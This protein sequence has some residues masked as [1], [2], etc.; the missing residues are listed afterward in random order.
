MTR[1]QR[2]PFGYRLGRIWAGSQMLEHTLEKQRSLRTATLN[3][4]SVATLQQPSAKGTKGDYGAWPRIK[5]ALRVRG[6]RADRRACARSVS[7]GSIT[8]RLASGT[9]GS[10]EMKPLSSGS[11]SEDALPSVAALVA[12]KPVTVEEMLDLEALVEDTELIFKLLQLACE[13]FFFEFKDYVREQPD[14]L[15]PVNMVRGRRPHG[16]WPPPAGCIPHIAAGIATSR[17]RARDRS[18]GSHRGPQVQ[19]ALKYLHAIYTSIDRATIDLTER[20]LDLLVEMAD[21]SYT[22]QMVI[23]ENKGMCAPRVSSC[24]CCCCCSSNCLGPAPQR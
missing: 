7:S 23:F 12:P 16:C 24:C 20:N 9:S 6:W 1:P 14:S 17:P 18:G 11:Q 21:G 19:E 8:D 4:M 10:V 15:H 22:N 5:G 2:P 3:A 13:D